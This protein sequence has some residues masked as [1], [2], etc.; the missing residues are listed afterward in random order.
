MAPDDHPE[1]GAGG[2]PRLFGHLQTVTV[3]SPFGIAGEET[4]PPRYPAELGEHTV[5]IM[6]E[7]GYGEDE[8]RRLIDA[9]V[10]V[11]PS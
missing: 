4:V 5:E 9:R 7:A 8:I 11:R 6:R 1:T 10:T 3:A 2:T